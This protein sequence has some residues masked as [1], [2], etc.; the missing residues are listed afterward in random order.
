MY[1]EGP[2]RAPRFPWPRL[3]PTAALTVP[4]PNV[5]WHT[6]ITY[7]ETTD[8]GLCALTR[9]LEAYT[10]EVFTHPFLPICGAAGAVEGPEGAVRREFPGAVRAEGVVARSDGGAQ[11]T[12]QIYRG[13]VLP[14]MG[15]GGDVLQEAPRRQRHGRI[16]PRKAENG[17]PLGPRTHDFSP[18]S[19]ARGV[20]HPQLERREAALLAG[21]SHT[22]QVSEEAE[23]GIRSMNGRASETKAFPPQTLPYPSVQKT[24][25]AS[26][27]SSSTRFHSDSKALARQPRSG[28]CR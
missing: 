26:L 4:T 14:P 8:R 19:G 27:A 9:I 18:D 12:S 21:L 24:G 22:D 3:P 11:F 10:R 2:S 16:L 13:R 25:A 7:V 28:T 20:G 6:D 1:V 5:R 23:S 17:L 15:P